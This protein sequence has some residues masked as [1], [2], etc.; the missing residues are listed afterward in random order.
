MRQVQL[1]GLHC[2][3]EAAGP[4]EWMSTVDRE[5]MMEKRFTFVTDVC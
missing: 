4:A 1:A 2:L 3:L 5:Y